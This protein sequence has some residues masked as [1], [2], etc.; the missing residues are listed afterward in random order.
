LFTY[1]LQRRF[2]RNST[3]AVAAHPGSSKSELSRNVPVAVRL[4]F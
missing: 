4:A 2:L 3:I 1:E